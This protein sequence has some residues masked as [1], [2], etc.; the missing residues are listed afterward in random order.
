MPKPRV[1]IK[2]IRDACDA[3]NRR[4]GLHMS[5]Q[6]GW[7]QFSDVRG[8][9]GPYRPRLYVTTNTQGGISRSDLNGK[10]HRETLWNVENAK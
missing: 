9:G 3:Y 1:T 8:D 2:Q 4:R 10:T 6:I 7:L 5:N